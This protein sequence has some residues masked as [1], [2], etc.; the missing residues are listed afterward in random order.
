MDILKLLTYEEKIGGLAVLETRIEALALNH[1]EKKGVLSIQSSAFAD[2]SK[3]TIEGGILKNKSAFASAVKDVLDKIKSESKTSSFI[4]SL[5]ADAVYC[6]IFSFP[7][8]LS[9]VQIDDAIKLNLGF[10]LPFS[11]QDA[12]LDWETIESSDVAKKE[13]I[14]CAASRNVI[15][16]YLEALSSANVA[17]V[18]VEFHSMS[19]ARVIALGS[20]EPALVAVI[21]DDNLEI[22]VIESGTLR[23]VQ[24]FDINRISAL[25]G[26]T[27][28]DVIVD[29]IWRLV[30]FYDSE[31]NKKGYLNKIYLAGDYEMVGKYKDLIAEKIKGANVEFSRLLPAFPKPPRSEN[32]NL[33]HIVLGAALRGLMPRREDTINSLMPMGTEEAYERKRK[34]SFMEFVSDLISALSVF[35]IVMFLGMWILMTIMAG[36]I[37]KSQNRYGALPEELLELKDKAMEFNET[38]S[39]INALEQKTPKWS[40]LINRL[41]MLATYG[42]VL[43]NISANDINVSI[44]GQAATRDALL[45]FKT[46]LEKSN[47]FTEVKVP[48]NYLEQKDNIPFSLALKLKDPQF[49][50]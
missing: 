37:E 47:L 1:D 6:H 14:L 26:K 25:G 18:A 3:G 38:I 30:N 32:S 2:L 50:K 12:Y 21:L 17:A 45:Q 27:V 11:P 20:K 46:V 41:P 15:D 36:N 28:E 4:I 33:P 8:T 5:P 16:E 7:H 49:L 23:F 31:K 29:K 35:F 9:E 19:V 42:I 22:S 24:A 34:I 40:R 39:Q 10:S 44:A 43:N 48:F 13:I